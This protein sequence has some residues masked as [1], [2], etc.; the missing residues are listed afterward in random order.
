MTWKKIHETDLL[1]V[2][3]EC[4]NRVS[5]NRSSSGFPLAGSMI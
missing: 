4:F 3:P 1:I 5:R 2:I